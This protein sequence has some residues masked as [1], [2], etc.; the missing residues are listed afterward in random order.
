MFQVR[1]SNSYKYQVLHFSTP[2]ITVDTVELSI[3]CGSQDLD[4]MHMHSKL[5]LDSK[6]AAT[7]CGL[8]LVSNELHD[9]EGFRGPTRVGAH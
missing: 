5:K 2:L 3:K 4:N 7:K 6:P 8:V 9:V 1:S